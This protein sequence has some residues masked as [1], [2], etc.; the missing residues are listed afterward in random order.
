[1]LVEVIV[2]GVLCTIFVVVCSLAMVAQAKCAFNHLNF[3]LD[4]IDQEAEWAHQQFVEELEKVKR[5]G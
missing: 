1:M 2:I 5:S 4:L 3:K